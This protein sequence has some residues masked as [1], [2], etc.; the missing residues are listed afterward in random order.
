MRSESWCRSSVSFGLSPQEFSLV[1]IPNP[2][3][4]ARIVESLQLD[5]LV[6]FS[7]EAQPEEEEMD[8]GA[9]FIQVLM[10][11]WFSSHSLLLPWKFQPA[12]PKCT[13]NHQTTSSPG[14]GICC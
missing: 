13:Y 10:R 6:M 11:L 3:P 5:S 14:L 2:R 7:F 8:M 9:P 1:S 12:P 4:T